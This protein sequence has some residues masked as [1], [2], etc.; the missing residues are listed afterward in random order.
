MVLLMGGTAST[1]DVELL[2][3]WHEV[4]VLR[5]AGPRPRMNWATAPGWSRTRAAGAENCEPR[6]A[7]L[8]QRIGARASRLVA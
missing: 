4:A 1:T 3:L 6:Y 7:A 5:R 2:L 8:P